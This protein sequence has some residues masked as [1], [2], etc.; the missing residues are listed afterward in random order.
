MY[1]QT[2]RLLPLL[3]FLL[4]LA[5]T[6]TACARGANPLAALPTADLSDN[7]QAQDAS[8]TAISGTVTSD[9]GAGVPFTATLTGAESTAEA[10]LQAAVE[11]LRLAEPE[12]QIGVAGG[13]ETGRSGGAPVTA[14]APV[15][16]E[17]PSATITPDAGSANTQVTVSGSGFP[18]N[19]R[20]DLYLAGLVR[21]SAARTAPT[22][23]ATATTDR[24]GNYRMSFVMPATWP[25]GEPIL[26]GKLAVL[27]ATQ[28][29]GVR[30]STSF[31]YVAPTA[32]TPTATTAPTFP[33]TPTFTPAPPP[34]ATP[35][36]TPVPTPAQNPFMEATPLTG[37]AG[38]QI[39]LRGGGFPANTTVNVHLGTFDAQVGGS[40]D[41]VRYAAVTTDSNGYFT[42]AFT[43]PATWPDGTA[44]EPG[45]LLIFVEANNFTQQASAV[46]TYVAPTPTPSVNPYARVQP[47][48]GSA[49]TQVTVQGGGFPANTQVSLYLSGLVTGRAAAAAAPN[50]YAT[51]TTNSAGE[52]RMTFT[53]PATW[54]DGRPIQNGR[55]AL[56]VATA[57]FSVRA[58]ATFD[59]T[60]PTPTTTPAPGSPSGWQGR[61]FTNPNLQGEPALV[62]TD[63]DVRFNWGLGSPDPLIPSD[64]FS[65]S[66]TRRA[67]F[68]SGLYR[69]TVEADDGVRLYVDDRLILESWQVGARRTLSIDYALTAGEHT[70]R[71]D[72]FE[73]RGEALVNLRWTQ[74]DFGWRGAYY[75]NPDLSGAPVLE[76]YDPAI[77][78]NWGAGSPDARVAPDRFSVRWTRRLQLDGGNY[79]VTATADDGIRIWIDEELILD[80]WQNNAGVE[81]FST[82]V[83]LGGGAYELRV[84]YYEAT[85][86]ARVQVQWEAIGGAPAPTATPGP[87]TGGVLFDD[88]PRNNRRGVNA[89]FCSGFESECNFGGC[90]QNYRLVWGPYCRESDYPYIEP[91]LYRV[92]FHGTGTVRAGATDYGATNELFAFGEYRLDLPGSF[93]F[94]WPGRQRGGYGFE[95]IAQSI[96]GYATIDRITIEYLGKQCR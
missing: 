85:G 11:T 50:S 12:E 74:Q 23:Y 88:D 92:T 83:H 36:P 95:T 52:Y 53:M 14:T 77:N 79:R 25:S 71:L 28:D 80:Q 5:L 47:A 22:T 19:V 8:M 45:L 39:T 57:D 44:V 10:A 20:V 96:G 2:N 15:L 56:L 21:A 29:F 58:S 46:F 37:S 18:A 81:T 89:T 64:E 32:A 17:G 94:C 30:A 86:D 65:A 6:L 67:T 51:A 16:T 75:N 42:T 9:A 68:D 87:T 27:V 4:L 78:F 70:I 55:L 93:T 69:F 49:N 48:A 33:P 76:R 41:T 54:P 7:D 73:N 38:I 35:T 84:E 40:G 90:P 60:E 66:W 31:D 82:D 61:Y 63:A 24:D 91:G 43:M 26:T 1:H 34:I 3:T 62:R 13:A 72:Y 59:Y